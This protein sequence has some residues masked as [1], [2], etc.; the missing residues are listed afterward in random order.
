MSEDYATP[1]MA[2]TRAIRKRC[3]PLRHVSVWTVLQFLAALTLGY[4]YGW[5]SFACGLCAGGGYIMAMV[6]VHGGSKW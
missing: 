5:D 4:A 2:T 1:R 6:D 3:N